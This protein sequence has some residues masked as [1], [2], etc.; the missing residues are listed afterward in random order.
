[1]AVNQGLKMY[2][3]E[4]PLQINLLKL[5]EEEIVSRISSGLDSIKNTKLY[6]LMRSP[7]LDEILAMDIEDKKKTEKLWAEWIDSPLK[8][9]LYVIILEFLN[10]GM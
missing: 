7:N 8:S 2:H 5:Y 10:S 4:T 9:Q 1:M 6:D 3:L